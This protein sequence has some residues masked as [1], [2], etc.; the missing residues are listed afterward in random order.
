MPARL[1]QPA[2]C[3]SWQEPEVGDERLACILPGADAAFETDAA[4]VAALAVASSAGPREDGRRSRQQLR[5]FLGIRL[6]ALSEVDAG[7][8]HFA[9]AGTPVGARRGGGVLGDRRPLAHAET[10]LGVVSVARLP[11]GC[12]GR[13]GRCGVDA[14]VAARSAKSTERA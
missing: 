6:V 2:R 12:R 7:E 13:D 9:V 4:E 10:G 1:V 5:L 11:V 3:P 14:I 8:P